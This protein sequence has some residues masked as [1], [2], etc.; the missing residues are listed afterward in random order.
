MHMNIFLYYLYWIWVAVLQ[1]LLLVL[2]KWNWPSGLEGQTLNID[3]T[4]TQPVYLSRREFKPIPTSCLFV[5]MGLNLDLTL[6]NQQIKQ[7]RFGLGRLQ[8]NWKLTQ[9]KGNTIW[10]FTPKHTSWTLT[11]LIILGTSRVFFALGLVGGQI[12]Y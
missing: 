11:W 7:V 2:P 1:L 6:L 4:Q 12:E 9:P 10:L 3:P 5:I 8:I